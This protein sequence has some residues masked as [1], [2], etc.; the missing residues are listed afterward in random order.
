[1][2]VA[3]ADPRQCIG[4]ETSA[5][6]KFKDFFSVGYPSAGRTNAA[7]KA[8]IADLARFV[9][10]WGSVIGFALYLLVGTIWGM[11]VYI[12]SPNNPPIEIAD[13][14]SLFISGGACAMGIAQIDTLGKT[15]FY[16]Y[17]VATSAA[18]AMT[19]VFC[20]L[21]FVYYSAFLFHCP[22]DVDTL[23]PFVC[24]SGIPYNTALAAFIFHIIITP[25]IF[26]GFWTSL[27]V[28]FTNPPPTLDEIK[29]EFR[30]EMI[31]QQAHYTNAMSEMGSQLTSQL[32]NRFPQSTT[33]I[34]M[35]Q[36][37]YAQPIY[38]QQ[39]STMPPPQQAL[40]PQQPSVYGM[41]PM[42]VVYGQPGSSLIN[43][44]PTAQ[45]DIAQGGVKYY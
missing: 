6:M 42:P 27:I 36:T 30:L 11:V 12:K 18:S 39:V 14:V 15:K 3:A 5:I 17:G 19:F 4:K 33:V 32:R 1:M 26:V 24:T 40:Y 44:I 41:Q 9:L 25:I 29:E 10:Y 8:Q 34:P 16:I 7:L 20:I 37:S 38:S 28:L 45:P 31:K 43:T 22:G 13:L 21:Y 2:Q 23:Q 35:E